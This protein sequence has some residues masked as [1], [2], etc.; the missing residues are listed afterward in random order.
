MLP[1]NIKLII[2]LT[3]GDGWIGYRAKTG[4]KNPYFICE[5]GEKQIDYCKYKENLLNSFGYVTTSID[6][7]NDNPT[8]KN[9]GKRSYR[10]Y[11]REHDDFHTG[12]KHI[13]NSGRKAIDNHLLRD[14]DE[15]SLAFW[16][17]DDGN[18]KTVQYT[19][20]HN[21]KIVYERKKVNSYILATDGFTYQENSL[22]QAWL[23]EKF[24]IVTKLNSVD[25]G[26]FYE[27]SIHGIENKENFRNII[28]PYVEKIPCL[29]YKLSYPS[30][31]KDIPV[32]NIIDN[33]KNFT[34]E[35]T[36]RNSPLSI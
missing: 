2:D 31:F 23:Y 22:I 4:R 35:E 7:V 20:S 36:E 14:L 1:K 24:A 32:A 3:I 9:F 19:I 11:T 8:S 10:F 12:F 26:K 6:R 27:L 5:H 18:A 16:F 15:E 28:L 34:A 25:K 33:Y 29:M 30:S 13:Y 17:M 21:R